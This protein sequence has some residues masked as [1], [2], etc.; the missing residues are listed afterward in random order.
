MSSNLVILAFII[1]ALSGL[2]VA[3]AIA[4]ARDLGLKMNW[5]KWLSAGL[6]YILLI[7][8]VLSS[9][10]LIGEGEPSAGMR[11]IFFMG[12]ITIILGVGVARVIFAGR[13]K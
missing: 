11:M 7:F 13:E 8:S 3:A 10:T 1:G 9:F 6:W 2:V 4:W 12:V 5:W